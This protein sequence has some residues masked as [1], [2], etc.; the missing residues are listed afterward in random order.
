MYESADL[1][2]T[3][4]LEGKSRRLIHANNGKEAVDCVKS[5]Q[6]IDLILMDIKMPLMDGYSAT[7]EIRKFNTDITIIAQTAYALEGDRE[8]V[9]NGGF[10]DYIAKPIKANELLQVI[11]KYVRS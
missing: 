9:L 7:N 10:N 4:L 2:L 11:S 1:Y 8:K 5:D 3:E 6:D